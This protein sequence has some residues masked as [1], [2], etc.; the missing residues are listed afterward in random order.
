MKILNYYNQIRIELILKF[1]II[2]R[3]CT[4]IHPTRCFTLNGMVYIL[5]YG[6]YFSIQG[7][8]IILTRFHINY[9]GCNSNIQ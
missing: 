3:R 7:Q 5:W 9:N 6:I 4:N 2:K 1:F 8:T